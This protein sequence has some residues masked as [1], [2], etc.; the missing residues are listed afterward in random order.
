MIMA[1]INNDISIIKVTGD[2]TIEYLNNII[3]NDITQVNATKSIYSC[4]LT[5]HGKFIADFFISHF[6]DSIF[7]IT[8]KKFK[9]NLI[10]GLNFYKLRSKVIIEDISKF[11]KYYFLPS[12]EES[13]FDSSEHSLGKT[14]CYEKSF[15]FIDPRLVKLGTHIISSNK[16]IN[17]TSLEIFEG[18]CLVHFLKN[19]ILNMH[20]IQDL[21]K[22]YPLENN[23]HLL[24]AVDFKKGCYI[25]QELTARMKLRNK[26]P[27]IIIPFIFDL[28]E[29][30]DL[31]HA[32]IFE[33]D[34]LVGEIIYHKDQYLFGQITF[35]KLSKNINLNMQFFLKD[36]KLTINKQ[37]WLAL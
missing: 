28:H 8:N 15:T 11:Y 7:L 32:D 20:L 33:N 6:N 31:N 23:L 21:T 18:D 24:N 36:H 35:R 30:N 27:R 13:I 19:G 37:A 16:N 10:K 14:N 17:N 9:E 4:L 25:G 34:N 12:I 3:T 29:K 22:V 5:P 26:I 1:F 2:D